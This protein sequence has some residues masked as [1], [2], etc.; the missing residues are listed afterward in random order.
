MPVKGL[1]YLNKS[2]F[3][4]RISRKNRLLPPFTALHEGVLSLGQWECA[5]ISL[6]G[7]AEHVLT[8]WVTVSPHPIGNTSK[9]YA[10]EKREFV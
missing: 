6:G 2:H 4:I 7:G 3:G 5:G 1:I 9:A 8:T 10:L